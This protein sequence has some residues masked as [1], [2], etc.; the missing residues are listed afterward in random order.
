MAKRIAA[1]EAGGI[2]EQLGLRE[3]DVLFSI[4]GEAVLDTIDYQAL[5]YETHIELSTSR[6]DFS[7]DKEEYEPLGVWLEADGV[8]LCVNHCPFC[9]VDQLPP[10]VRESMRVKDDD[11]RQSLIM[12][13]FVTLTNVYGRELEPHHPARRFAPVHF[14]A[15]YAARTAQAIAGLR[16][17]RRNF[18]YAFAL[19]GG[20]HFLSFAG[21]ALPRAERWS[22]AGGNDRGSVGAAPGGA[23]AGAGARGADEVPRRA[24]SV[25]PVC[26]GRGAR[27][28]GRLRTAG[29]RNA[30]GRRIRALSFHRMS[31]ISLAG[32]ELPEDEAYEDYPQIDNG[33]GMLR[34]FAER[35]IARR[36]RNCASR[37]ARARV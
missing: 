5:T 21:R 8:R 28:A 29:A 3:G 12:G 26:A 6:G 33:V 37:R 1:L 14:R 15:R 24:N 19:E 11:W 16:A 13:N 23:F 25:A 30:F 32:R 7:F 9:F 27:G 31:F 2:A 20:W 35:N 34:L 10:H 36:T 18:G 4:N 17:G 22:G